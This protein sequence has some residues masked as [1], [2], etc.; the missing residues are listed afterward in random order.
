M[1]SSRIEQAIEK[2]RENIDDFSEKHFPVVHRENKAALAVIEA[3][4]RLSN[5]AR[6]EAVLNN[7]RD[8]PGWAETNDAL[9]A[10]ADAVLGSAS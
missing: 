3:A 2:A 10:W 6:W 5:Q 1:T 8:L 9:N 4:T 7:M